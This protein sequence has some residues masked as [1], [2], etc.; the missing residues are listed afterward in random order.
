MRE[1]TQGKGDAGSITNDEDK[2]VTKS[3]IGKVAFEERPG[4]IWRRGTES[5]RAM[6]KILRP[7]VFMA[8]QGG[9]G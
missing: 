4:D 6:A 1:G 3:L 2:V 5:R 9:H 8:Q 7:G